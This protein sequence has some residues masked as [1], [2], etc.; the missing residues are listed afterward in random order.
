[1]NE[2]RTDL[3]S[4][5][6]RLADRIRLRNGLSRLRAVQPPAEPAREAPRPVVMWDSWYHEEALRQPEQPQPPAP[7]S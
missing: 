5:V 7:K 4:N 1:M 3:P 6:Y 2:T